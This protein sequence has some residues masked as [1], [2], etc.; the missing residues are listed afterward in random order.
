MY[1]YN[2]FEQQLVTSKL[3][4]EEEKINVTIPKFPVQVICM[5]YCEDTFDSLIL[6]N[7]LTKDEWFS[8]LMQII[9]ILITYQKAFNFTHNDLHT[10]N[11]MYNE[12]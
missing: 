6:N 9:M 11:V 7:D 10:N 8:S 2:Y 4:L 3:S 1:F 5:E 12:D